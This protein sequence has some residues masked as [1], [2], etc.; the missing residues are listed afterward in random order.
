MYNSHRLQFSAT[1]ARNVRC[2]GEHVDNNTVSACAISVVNY[3][4]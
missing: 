4:G 3:N 1:A 2:S